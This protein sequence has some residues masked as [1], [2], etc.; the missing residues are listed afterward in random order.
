MEHSFFTLLDK[1]KDHGSIQ[2]PDFVA[3]TMPLIE[4]VLS[5]HEDNKV[6]FITHIN[7]LEFNQGLLEIATSPKDF[8]IATQAL[9]V[10]PQQISAIEVSGT[11]QANSNL[12]TNHTEYSNLSI[13]ENMDELLTEPKYLIGY[14][15]WDYILGHY[16]PVTEIFVLGQLLASIAF[17]LDFRKKEELELFIDNR[18]R[19][20]FL[21]KNLH[22]TLLNIVY[23]MTHLYRED[24][25]ANLEEIV[26]K[27]KNYREYNPE[28]YIDL[29]QTEGFRNQD[30]SERGSWILS[31]LKNRLFDIS[32]RNKLL[33]FTDRQNFMNLTIA[34]V[35]LL[36]DHNN[37]QEKDLIFWNTAIA[38]K[39]VKTKKLLLNNYLEFNQNRFLAPTL[40]K[41]R[42]EASKSSNEY[43]FSQLRT[44][45]AFIHWYNFKE[46]AEER[47]TTPLLLLPTN[48]VKKKGVSDQYI[49]EYTSTE[50]EI[51]PILSH[52]LKELYDI[53]LP[54][55]IDL[56]T[57][58]VEELVAN[59]QAQIAGSGTGII[60]QWRKIPKIQLIHSIAQKN[61]NLRSKTL[62]NRS[63]GLNLRAFHYSYDKL[64]YQPLGLQ[65]F[66]NRIRP[67]NNAL[68]YIINEDLSPESDH[69]VA[70]KVRT[71][72]NTDNE[73]DINPLVWEI[74][75]CNLTVGNFNY[76]KM[77]LVRDY[78]E[79]IDA[80]LKDKIFEQLF[81]E[82]P[83]ITTPLASAVTDLA[84]NYPIIAA[85]PTQT[86]AIQIARTGQS[87]II[88]GPPGTGKS[89]TITN[90]IADY[91]AR[92]KKILFVC[93]KRA[94]LDVVFH[95][96]KNKH[97]DELC[98]LIHDSQT[99]KK[100]FIQ[101]LKATYENWMANTLDDEEIN[102]KRS[103]LIDAINSE[104]ARLSRF[105]S[106]MAAHQ[107]DVSPLELF[108]VL[109]A[110]SLHKSPAD[111]IA[112]INYPKYKEWQENRDWILEW[113]EQLKHNGFDK[114]IAAYPF[115]Q[116]SSNLT[117]AAN[118]KALVLE[119]LKICSQY[120]DEFGELLDEL[121][122]PNA[123]DRAMAYWTQKFTLAE[124]LKGIL[125]AGKIGVLSHDSP[126]ASEF[127]AL[128]QVLQNTK[129]K[130][131]KLDNETKNWRLKLSAEDTQAALS[132][133]TKYESSFLKYI[134]PAYYK[135]KKNIE[136]AY[137]FTAHKIKPE[138]TS[139]LQK[140]NTYHDTMGHLL[141]Q[142]E[143]FKQ[144]F[145]LQNIDQEV[146]WI[147]EMQVNPSLLIKEWTMPDKTQEISILQNFQRKWNILLAECSLV[148][149]DISQ[150]SFKELE[151]TLANGESALGSLSVFIPFIEKT[152]E[153]TSEMQAL[154]YTKQWAVQ[155]FEY[156]LAYKSLADIYDKDREFS[157]VD[158]DR[159]QSSISRIDAMLD[160]Y[161][162]SNVDAIRSRIRLQFLNKIRISES[163]AAQLT[164]DEKVAKKSYISA[165]RILENEFSKTMRY[166]SIRELTS[167]DASVLMNALKPVWLMSPLSVSDTMPIDTSLFDVVIYDEASQ[168]TVEE[169]VP[170]LFRTHQTIIV[171]DEMQMPPTNFFASS[172]AVDQEEEEIEDKIGIS[173]DADSLLNQGGRKLSSV[174]LGWHYRSRHE[175][176]ISF[177]NAA[178]YKRSLLTIPDNWIG[179]AQNLEPLPAILDLDAEVNV[180]DILSRNISYCYLEN[181]VYDKRKNRDEAQ[182]IA[183]LVRELLIS[184]SKLSIGIVAFSMDQQSEIEYAL[185]QLAASDSKF[186][187]MLEDEYNRIDQD[188]FNGLFVKNLENV[189]GDER[190]IIIMSV[191]YGS[192]SKG[193]MLMN[194]GPINRRGGEKRLNVIF[195]RAKKRMVVVSS[196]LPNE[197]KNDYNEGANYFKR[198]LQYA[199]HIS[200]GKLNEANTILN[201]LHLSDGK[202]SAAAKLTIISQ[203]RHALEAKGYRVDT[204]VGQSHFKCDLGIIKSGEN[205][206][207][208]GILIDKP[209]HYEN[210]NVLEQYC[211]KPELLRAFGWQICR[212]LSKD[213]LEQPERVLD[214]IDQALTQKLQKPKVN[215]TEFLKP[216]AL[217]LVETKP[218]IHDL[219]AELNK[220][221]LETV[222][223]KAITELQKEPP[224]AHVPEATSGEVSS[225]FER[226]E[227]T[228]GAS[229]KYWQ[230]AVTDMRV[231]VQYGRIGNQPQS[232]TKTYDSA[233]Q[234]VREKDKMVAKKIAKGYVKV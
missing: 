130:L 162:E 113:K 78:N 114:H 116:L 146:A 106:A 196:I 56:E 46:V 229:N 74:D 154:L 199:K 212:V 147:K 126:S 38:G 44:V 43:G 122:V 120:M 25:S 140:L 134:N 180:N 198:F 4:Q 31:K 175:S 61:F 182:Y 125:K 208:L 11:I 211:Q 172:N 156:Q 155:D 115:V 63:S 143:S 190:D 204:S 85:D 54:D 90:L 163:L 72:Y 228:E 96:L 210:K 108:E 145:G 174:M 188:Q 86:A 222:A 173:L 128:L 183:K 17:G 8:V 65:I 197:I 181:A 7:Q 70:E 230:V 57:T 231:D 36:L 149:G 81:S 168:I 158:E 100:A 40:N 201:T 209:E 22:P 69:A 104:I 10:K 206:Y 50:A 83:K 186:E 234:A 223:D 133:W 52:Y 55:F 124:K 151:E 160:M 62:D 101:N 225:A 24:R 92:D 98:C 87:Y 117:L 88:Q 109:H 187:S 47:I 123:D 29:T 107:E 139:I 193:K 110:T 195:S 135:L 95:R 164:P 207:E 157:D 219:I 194:F 23:E 202:T 42:L 16:D 153:L 167:S 28:N 80:K 53:Q 131:A 60:L 19:L 111:E 213:W 127:D 41:I 3:Y 48:V 71:F 35:P 220:E 217:E 177:S 214:K 82:A 137:N 170:S 161:Y 84:K 218:K 99:D 91:V 27:L 15:S 12:D 112:R 200:D 191:C 93:E 9:F 18:K 66:N 189:Q 39:I 1:I 129:Q 176:L 14:K 67:K 184:K 205:R 233:E 215:I 119:K 79:I 68:E 30:V 224:K 159:L 141:T 178:F 58:T 13:H 33:Y 32:R 169:G 185:D 102:D 136:S 20:Y 94:A 152:K 77:S 132:Q 75:T 49:L 216:E 64:D 166:K 2:S 21:N 192:N 97:L 142:K 203:L 103:K 6:A 89:Q 59:I 26:V 227:Y 150:K 45:I 5:L 221:E 171:G 232:S 76:R 138:I 73:G 165:R 51:N 226:Y 144:K 34:S 121:D 179:N 118:P 37:I 105:H 148:L